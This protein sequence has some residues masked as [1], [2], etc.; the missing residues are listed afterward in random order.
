MLSQIETCVKSKKS[1]TINWSQEEVD[2]KNS[3]YKSTP[4][5]WIYLQSTITNS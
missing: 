5:Y 2:R 4:F 3:A 1:V